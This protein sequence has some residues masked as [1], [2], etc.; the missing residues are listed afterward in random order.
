MSREPGSRP[1]S[2]SRRLPARVP[3]AVLASRWHLDYEH[4]AQVLRARA[5]LGH[6]EVDAR[7]AVSRKPVDIPEEPSTLE[8][9][10]FRAIESIRRGSSVARRPAAAFRRAS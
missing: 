3:V 1:P 9:L 4:Y 6:S 7:P 2:P 8:R 10:W 5:E